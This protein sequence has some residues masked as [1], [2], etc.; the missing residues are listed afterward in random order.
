M[1]IKSIFFLLL[2]TTITFTLETRLDSLKNA[3]VNSS[4]HK[5]LQSLLS[6]SREYFDNCPEKSIEFGNRALLLA[7][8][9]KD[10]DA[11]I[12]AL[13]IIG[14]A[15]E[16]QEQKTAAI[17]FYE[18]GLDLAAKIDNPWGIIKSAM[19]L[20]YIFDDRLNFEEALIKYKRALL[21][22]ERINDL[23]TIEVCHYNIGL[24][25]SKEG[26]NEEALQHFFKALEIIKPDNNNTDLVMVLDL[27]GDMYINLADYD[28]ALKYYI[29]SLKLNKEIT[30]S[31]G[32][33]NSYNNL[34]NLYKNLKNY[35]DAQKYYE[36]SHNLS[37]EL[38]DKYFISIALN[39]LAIIQSCKGNQD[40]ALDFFH[41]ALKIDEEMG[42]QE[43][44]STIYNNL[45]TVY[46]ELKNY[47]RALEYYLK[48]LSIS[49]KQLDKFA[50][51]NTSN[52]IAE[53]YYNSGRYNEA[54][55]FI[56]KGLKLGEELKAKDLILESYQTYA[57]LY[58]V[59]GNFKQAYQYNRKYSDLSDSIYTE[60][61]FDVA[62]LQTKFETEKKE[63][64]IELLEKE[65]GYQTWI[66]RIM[67]IV[68]IIGLLI[69]AYLAYLFRAKNRENNIRKI[70]ENKLKESEELFRT[71]T[72]ELKTAV[73]MINPAG[74]ILYCNPQTCILTG[75]S[76]EELLKKKI[77]ELIHPDYIY[78][79][80]E[81]MRA[82]EEINTTN[83]ELKI[84]TKKGYE[85]WIEISNRIII[86]KGDSLILG[87]A[88]DITENKKAQN[89]QNVL[90]NIS[91]S[92][93]ITQNLDE[94][95]RNIHQQLSK[96]IDTKNFYIALYDINT[97]IITA[98]Y[99]IDEFKKEIPPPQILGK[100]LTGYIIRTTKPLFLTVDKRNELVR[101]KE[102]PEGDWKSKIWLGVPLM[103][104]QKVIGA[105]V[106]QNYHNS[107]I[108]S[109]KD[110]N[111]LEIVSK[112]VAVAIEKKKVE[113]ELT[114][115]EEKF[116]IVFETTQDIIFIKNTK[117]QYVYV[118]PSMEKFYGKPRLDFYGKINE[119]IFENKP[120]EQI[121]DDDLKTLNGEMV[122]SEYNIHL[123]DVISTLDILKVPLKDETSKII[124]ICGI[125][126]DITD[127]KKA[128]EKIRA[129]LKEKEVMV[130]EI[131][132]RVK[133]N[134]QV[135]T[136][137]LKLQS[138]YIRDKQALE[139]FKDS[140]NRVRSMALVHEKLY[141]SEDLA[142]IKF[143]NYI[144]NLGSSLLGFYRAHNVKLDIKI[145]EIL[146]PV[147]TA[148]PCGLIANELISNSL[149]YAFPDS[150]KGVI[151]ISMIQK[152]D[153][154]EFIISDNGIRLPAELDIKNS[155]TFGLQLVLTLVEQLHGTIRIDNA[156]GAA[157]IINF[158]ES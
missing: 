139:L 38:S 66:K 75:Y 98:P 129:S 96:I 109:E 107:D 25:I 140:M 15:Y 137:L 47:E 136:S 131:H 72:E 135:I 138:S 102:I 45:G 158:K 10:S 127:R 16:E 24:I 59:V 40:K 37:I 48:S 3:L 27:I 49:E 124:G 17:E 82:D 19:N 2:I 50:I 130:Q 89:I 84:R 146:F 68:F 81:R 143:A 39:N 83:Y 105:L 110:L 32:I 65:K 23:E 88:S 58:A 97:N 22:A 46:H 133:N 56:S 114:K 121:L 69:I 61:V 145:K 106:V 52:N 4:G 31:L 150:A 5:K 20:A 42:Y 148:I 64:Q 112:Q 142:S 155:E 147:N 30:D 53:L 43:G 91:N 157:F 51:A 117:L 34:G 120:L 99:Y 79:I 73:F 134:M 80:K 103:I 57:E 151:S 29:E 95:F 104:G 125:A 11:K 123:N 12:N 101:K 1:K 111:I 128:D 35:D 44:I 55:S 67:I 94:L 14:N 18:R 93:N 116:R 86:L 74:A 7:D 156:K 76:L 8:S 41:E 77:Y 62:A 153:D 144:Q 6:I 122:H 108:Y 60:N 54:F 78:L 21:A 149:K 113:D 33:A 118:N 28:Q 36:M 100:G 132:H 115:S 71:L 85:R 141:S 63:A 119:E 90:F 152:T 13:N 92:V 26:N 126:R 70:T 9:L 87:T 154:Y